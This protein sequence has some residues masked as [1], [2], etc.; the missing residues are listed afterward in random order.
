MNVTGA[1][2]VSTP[3]RVALEDARKGA[4]MFEKVNI[5]VVGLVENMS[6]FVCPK[7]NEITHVFGKDHDLI[8]GVKSLG[9][10]PLEV[11]IMQTADEGTPFVLTHEDTSTV[12]QYKK[13]AEKIVN[14]LSL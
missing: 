1:L 12:Q 9:K 7:C 4:Q 3:Q 14:A 10:I 13:I 8:E 11:K 5:P 6:S 2:I